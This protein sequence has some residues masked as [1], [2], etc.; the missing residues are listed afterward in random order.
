MRIGIV[1]DTHNHLGNVALIV[2]RF[3]AA[4]VI[5][6]IHTGDVTQPKVIDAFARLAVPLVGVYGNNDIGEREGLDAAAARHGFAFHEGPLTLHWC[7]RRLVVVHDPASL[8][9]LDTATADLVLHGH[10]HRL[11]LR[12]DRQTLIFNPGECAGHLPGRNA[13]G[14]IDLSSPTLTPEL[15]RF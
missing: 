9:A 14:V 1:S 6:V 7:E 8:D 5:R 10:D 11:A 13:V 15:L 2:A 12:R 4:G 3:R